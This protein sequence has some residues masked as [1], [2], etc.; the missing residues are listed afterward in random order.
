MIPDSNRP[1]RSV[2]RWIAYP[3]LLMLPIACIYGGIRLGS[4]GVASGFMLASH[5]HTPVEN[6]TLSLITLG[7]AAFMYGYWAY[8]NHTFRFSIGSFILV[9]AYAAMM[10][11]FGAWG[12]YGLFAVLLVWFIIKRATVKDDEAGVQ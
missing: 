7:V 1:A 3:L 2:S 11:V 4:A 8:S 5:N 9:I 12:L 6:W 10:F